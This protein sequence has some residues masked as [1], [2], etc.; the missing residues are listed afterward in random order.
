MPS[1]RNELERGADVIRVI[2]DATLTPWGGTRVC[3]DAY[4]AGIRV[5]T[6]VQ[7]T[8]AKTV[9]LE[10]V[11]SVAATCADLTRDIGATQ[12]SAVRWFLDA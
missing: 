11:R 9:R 3:I 2:L 6:E 12:L 5:A 4:E 7:L 8:V 10:P 1:I